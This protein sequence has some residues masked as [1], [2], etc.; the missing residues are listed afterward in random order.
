[1]ALNIGGRLTRWQIL[2]AT[3][4]FGL[5]LIVAPHAAFSP[6]VHFGWEV[7]HPVTLIAEGIGIALVSSGVLGFTIERW[8]RSDLAKDIIL[9]AIGLHLPDPYRAALRSELIRLSGYKFVCEKHIL[10][11]KI[12]PV[13]A[14]CVRITTL[15]ERT[16]K[17]IF[18]SSEQ[19]EGY[20]HIDDWQFSQGQSSISE[21][22]AEL[23]GGAL[24]PDQFSKIETHSNLSISARTAKIKIKPNDCVRF[25]AKSIEF[26]RPT[27]ELSFFYGAPTINPTI[28]VDAPEQFKFQVS[29]GPDEEKT[30]RERYSARTTLE[31]IYWPLQRMR[32]HWWQTHDANLVP[33]SLDNL[34]I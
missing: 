16:F 10:K 34:D 15:T 33:A 19:F 8:L 13:D 3:L 2:L 26:K 18:T 4:T 25:T 20:T 21:C 31:G 23:V 28:E 5:L 32:V 11:I 14:N 7:G 29:F 1:M 17:N 9:T 6:E 27:D 24:P 22:Q 12:E 30:D